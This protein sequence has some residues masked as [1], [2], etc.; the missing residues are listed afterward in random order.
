MRFSWAWI[1]LACLV[2]AS[3]RDREIGYGTIQCHYMMYACGDRTP[4]YRVDSIL[5]GPL[6][7]IKDKDIDVVFLKGQDEFDA[8]YGISDCLICYEFV[9]RGTVRSSGDEFRMIAD[10]ISRRLEATCCDQQ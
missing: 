9:V 5:D 10:T 1:V 2:Q 8:A 7:I 3:C 6:T 4:Q